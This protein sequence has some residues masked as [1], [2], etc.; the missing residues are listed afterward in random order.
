MRGGFRLERQSS[1]QQLR[2]TL[3]IVRAGPTRLQLIVQP[4]KAQLAKAQ[5]PIMHRRADVV[6]VVVA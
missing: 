2:D 1:V 3:L 6:K 5:A 4:G